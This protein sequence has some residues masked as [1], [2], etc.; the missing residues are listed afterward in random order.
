MRINTEGL[1]DWPDPDAIHDGASNLQAAGGE[2]FEA[3]GA[4]RNIWRELSAHYWTESAENL[5]AALNHPADVSAASVQNSTTFVA[6]AL[7]VFG[8]EIGV[9]RTYIPALEQE[10]EAYNSYTRSASDEPGTPEAAAEEER[11]RQEQG[12]DLQQRVDDLV[13]RYEEAIDKCNDLLNG[14]SEDGLPSEDSAAWLDFLASFG[15][16]VGMAGLKAAAAAWVVDTCTTTIRHYDTG[17][18]GET[19]PRRVRPRNRYVDRHHRMDWRRLIETDNVKNGSYL[20]RFRRNLKGSFVT[21]P[22]MVERHGGVTNR[23]HSDTTGHTTEGRMNHRTA[24]S[25]VGRGLGRALGAAGTALLLHSEYEQADQ[26]L[27]EERPELSDDERF[28]HAAGT[29]AARGGSQI[30]VSAVAGAAIG[31]ALP[32]GGTAVGLVVGLAV[33]VA[34]SIPTGDDKSIGDRIGDV[35]E[36]AFNMAV[37]LFSSPVPQGP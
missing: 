21:P 17:P 27:K 25:S 28:A 30:L 22:N 35:G 29:A 1:K 32:V 18:N 9:L 26:R 5:Y 34:M 23:V 37:D 8:G 24:A 20:E 15:V 10:A 11:A 4:A 19:I 2:F 3:V 6:G 31:S 14:I 7:T 36:G 12:R 13:K 33:G 16:N